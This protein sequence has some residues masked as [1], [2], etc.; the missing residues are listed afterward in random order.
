[1]EWIHKPSELMNTYIY[2]TREISTER[3]LC[4]P[5]D[6]QGL[7]HAFL[8]PLEDKQIVNRLYSKAC[9]KEFD[10]LVPS[11]STLFMQVWTHNSTENVW[12]KPKNK[13]ETELTTGSD[14]NIL[15]VMGIVSLSSVDFSFN[16]LKSFCWERFHPCPSAK[17]FLLSV[18]FKTK[19]KIVRSVTC[20]KLSQYNGY[21]K[22]FFGL[23]NKK[24][25]KKLKKTN[26]PKSCFIK[27]S[28]LT[29]GVLRQWK[30][31]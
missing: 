23:R 28:H 16:E 12:K 19:L 2:I 8:M 9:P 26:A 4:N 15:W 29:R 1:M 24:K 6:P 7:W 3:H 5:A 25:Q 13:K 31:D 20:Q 17:H 18:P 30:A 14:F 21:Q 10:S 11:I 22:A 27:V